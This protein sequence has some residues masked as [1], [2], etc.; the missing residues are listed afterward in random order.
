[1]SARDAASEATSRAELSP[2]EASRTSISEVDLAYLSLVSPELE[3]RVNEYRRQCAPES[4]HL[5]DRGMAEE[6]ERRWVL[7]KDH[8][9]GGLHRD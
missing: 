9:R 1:M 8:L 6:R 5:D 3:E 7:L 2:T 4:P